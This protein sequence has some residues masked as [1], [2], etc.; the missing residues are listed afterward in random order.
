VFETGGHLARF[1]PARAVELPLKPPAG[2]FAAPVVETDNG[3]LIAAYRAHSSGTFG[4][5]RWNAGKDELSPVVAAK[6]GVHAVQPVA[7]TARAVPKKH[8]SSLG[9]RE[10]ANL[11]CL[12]VYTSKLNVPANTAASV[13]VWMR[14]GRSGQA[15][16]L[17]EAPV[18]ADGSFFVQAP[19]DRPI[20]FEVLDRTGRTIAAE[21][22]WWWART[23][24]QRIC[25]GCHA[26]PER[27]AENAVPEILTHSTDPTR[28]IPGGGQATAASGGA[29]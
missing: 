7:V 5:Y 1:T 8:P 15:L 3:A 11:L 12:S 25:T 19:S 28:L 22:G 4:L 13:R 18:A 14:D 20:R 10:G 17:G 16:A 2:E 23:G 21:K 26:G 29:K 6:P 24:E 27:A 9:N